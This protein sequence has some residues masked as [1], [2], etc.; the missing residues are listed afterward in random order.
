MT[1]QTIE[2]K[3]REIC[4]VDED[5]HKNKYWEGCP[6]CKAILILID[7]EKKE[8]EDRCRN[9]KNRIH[10]EDVL[11][12]LNGELAIER[13]ALQAK[14]REYEEAFGESDEEAKEE[15]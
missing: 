3:V 1:K 14:C 12:Q 4:P 15:R 6:H 11:H 2:D 7:Q 10:G 5:D 9:L 13:D 8:L